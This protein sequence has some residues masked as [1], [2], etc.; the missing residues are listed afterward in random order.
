MVVL[1]IYTNHFACRFRVTTTSNHCWFSSLLDSPTDISSQGSYNVPL[2]PASLTQV[3]EDGT[4]LQSH[5]F[6]TEMK[7]LAL[8]WREW[9]GET[10]RGQARANSVGEVELCFRPLFYG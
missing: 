1:T 5:L 2:T 8:W 10:Q 6:G 7:A 3:A 9:K 4:T